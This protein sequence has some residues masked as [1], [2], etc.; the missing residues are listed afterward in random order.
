MWL[1]LTFYI[2]VS[3]FTFLVYIHTKYMPNKPFFSYFLYN[4]YKRNCIFTYNI[5]MIHLLTAAT[6][7]GLWT[8]GRMLMIKPWVLF[9]L[10]EEPSCYYENF[11]RRKK[12][13]LQHITE[14]QFI[15]T[16]PRSCSSTSLSDE[17]IQYYPDSV[18]CAILNHTLLRHPY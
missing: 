17:K 7:L 3:F 12:M 4:I 8:K 11:P 18:S 13:Q 2:Q 5:C 15:I 1:N 9:L 10:S 6:N 14:R 16:G